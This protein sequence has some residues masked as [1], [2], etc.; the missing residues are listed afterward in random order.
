M[1]EDKVKQS[2]RDAFVEYLSVNGLRCTTER[3]AILD[4]F[5]AAPGH[6]TIAEMAQYFESEGFPISRAT[7]Y[8]NVDLLVKAGFVRC[9]KFE[10]RVPEYERIISGQQHVHLVCSDCGTIREVRDA[11][12]I[13]KLS[14]LHFSGFTTDY[15]ALAVYG[16]CA[17]CQRRRRR[18][19]K[20]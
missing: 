15:F 12:L 18:S 2:A 1:S 16:T 7:L 4:I 5:L 13:R 11:E 14:S 6:H 3:L 9:L 19:A 8:N 10:G 17:K 20:H